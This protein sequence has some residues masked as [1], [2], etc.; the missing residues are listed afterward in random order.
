MILH[1]NV[2]QIMGFMLKKNNKP[3]LIFIV[4]QSSDFHL[5]LAISLRVRLKAVEGRGCS[6]GE[7]G[8]EASLKNLNKTTLTGLQI[9]GYLG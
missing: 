1:H 4:F 5:C 6:E 9:L 2:L 8:A 3:K 7:R